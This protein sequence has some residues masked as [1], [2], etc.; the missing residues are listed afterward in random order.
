[1]YRGAALAFIGGSLVETGG[2]NPI[3]A[4]AAGVPALAGPHMDNFR[5]I[6]ARG[7]ELHVLT[8]VRDEDELSRRLEDA[9][10][11]PAQSARRGAEAARFVAE[12]RGAAERTVEE[13]LGL[14]PSF[15]RR[16]NGVGVGVVGDAAP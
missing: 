15:S 13:L 11:S 9:L 5:E 10:A 4:W 1:V 7:E 2:Q 12:S 16:R 6:A 3:E 8:R 14:V